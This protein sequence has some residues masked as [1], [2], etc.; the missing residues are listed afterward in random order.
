MEGLENDDK[1]QIWDWYTCQLGQKS[2]EKFAIQ[3]LKVADLSIHFSKDFM[4]RSLPEVLQVSDNTSAVG[5]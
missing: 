2:K 5:S 1:L 3:S 4:R